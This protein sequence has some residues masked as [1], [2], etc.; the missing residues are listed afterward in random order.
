MPSESQE[1]QALHQWCQAKRLVSYAVPN[2]GS[3]NMLE[4]IKMKKEG[5]TAGVSDYVVMLSHKILFIEMKK[6]RKK[7]KN[8]KM[9]KAKV[10]TTPEQVKFLNHVNTLPYAAGA[11]C[12]GAKEAIAFIQKELSSKSK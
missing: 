3:R 7:L 9:S 6:R 11:V 4:A 12:E 1:Q 10:S 2:G 5:I 8:G